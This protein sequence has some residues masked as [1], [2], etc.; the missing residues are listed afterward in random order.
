[1][2]DTNEILATSTSKITMELVSLCSQIGQLI[3]RQNME[4]YLFAWVVSESSKCVL[5][6]LDKWSALVVNFEHSSWLSADIHALNRARVATVNSDQSDQ[7]Y[8]VWGPK[9]V[10]ARLRA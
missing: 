9:E 5:S 1:M 2:L 10:E 3:Q 6:L 8:F 4:Y 7:G